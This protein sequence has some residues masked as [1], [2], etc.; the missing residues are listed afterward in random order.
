[1]CS[2]LRGLTAIMIVGTA[3]GFAIAAPVAGTYTTDGATTGTGPWTLTSTDSTFSILRFSPTQAIP[4]SQ[5]SS[6]SVGY[7]AQLGG[8]GG[9]S[10]RI[11]VV[12][13]AVA[14]GVIGPAAGSFL[15]HWGPPGT[16]VDPTLGLG[17]TGNLLAL[18]DNGRYDLTNIGGSFYTDRA[19]AL[20][21]AAG[22]GDVIRFSIILDSFGGN[23][24]RFV[25][26]GVTADSSA[27]APAVPEPA[28][29]AL[30]GIVGLAGSAVGFSR[31][32]LIRQ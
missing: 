7:D 3:A 14:D 30:W 19:A 23:D 5:Y 6:L 8:I 28:S 31:R 15:I 13:D 16:F 32:R 4:F 27:A 26:D 1:M 25:I 2:M 9:G 24:R 29:L 21:A 20:I 22:F 12:L 10:P 11:A 18:T 17:N